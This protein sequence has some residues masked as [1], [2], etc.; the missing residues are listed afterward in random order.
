MAL[1][2][3]IWV[4]YQVTCLMRTFL[5]HCQVFLVLS[6]NSV[7]SAFLSYCTNSDLITRTKKRKKKKSNMVE[8]VVETDGLHTELKNS[9]FLVMLQQSSHHSPA[10]CSLIGGKATANKPAQLPAVW[11]YNTHI[12]GR[13]ITIDQDKRCYIMWVCVS[14]LRAGRT[15]MPSANK[16]FLRAWVC[17]TESMSYTDLGPSN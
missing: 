3:L 9:C 1:T 8:S 13:H 12:Y 14:T 15:V 11:R 10:H 4:K 7:D 16:A 5:I 17:S 6:L 2:F